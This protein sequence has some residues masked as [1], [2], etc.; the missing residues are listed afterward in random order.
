MRL[1]LL[2]LF[3]AAAAIAQ[4]P[5]IQISQTL[6]V[7]GGIRPA[8]MN[9]TITLS[10][11]YT[12]QDG[13]F[14]VVQSEA[15]IPIVGGHLSTCQPAG[16][17]I[18]AHYSVTPTPPLTKTEEYDRYWK[19]PPSGGPYPL[20]QIEG[21]TPITPP[22]TV[23][24]SWLANG[25]DGVV[26]ISGGHGDARRLVPNDLP[27]LVGPETAAALS[28][29]W[30][31]R[32]TPGSAG[33]G[34]IAYSPELR[35]LVVVSDADGAYGHVM[36]SD[37][38]GQTWTSH[39]T[40]G[41]AYEWNALMWVDNLS[42]FIVLPHSATY[43]GYMTSS[44]GIAWT[45]HANSTLTGGYF[46][47]VAW[48][49][50]LGI[51]CAV[52]AAA[53]GAG[54]PMAARSSD[55]SSWIAADGSSPGGSD[56]VWV[57]E[58]SLF[59][60]VRNNLNY[61]STS[62]DCNHWTA[63]S[64]I[65][66]TSSISTWGRVE[67]APQIGKLVVTSTKGTGSDLR[68]ASSPDAVHWTA[69]PSTDDSA[70]WLA[71]SWSP[72]LGLFSAISNSTAETMY[73]FDGDH[74]FAGVAPAPSTGWRR[75]L[76]VPEY[77]EF[78]AS[79]ATG[80]TQQIM[81]S[82]PIG[83]TAFSPQQVSASGGTSQPSD[84]IV[85]GTGSGLTS[86]D[87]ATCDTAG[88]CE[89]AGSL[90]FGGYLGGLLHTD[91]NGHLSAAPV[92]LDS[93]D[94]A[95]VLQPAYG[96]TGFSMCPASAICIAMPNDPVAGTTVN[97]MVDVNAGPLV[98][99][100]PIWV[101]SHGLPIG[102]CIAQCG[103]TGSAIIQIS[104]V[105]QVVTDTSTASGA[106]LVPSITNPGQ[107]SNAGYAT[108]NR[109][110][111]A[112]PI[113]ARSLDDGVSPGLHPVLLMLGPIPVDGFRQPGPLS[114]IPST[115]AQ[116]SVYFATDAPAGSNLRLCIAL[117]T[118]AAVSLPWAQLTGVPTSFA[119]SGHAVT[120]QYGGSDPVG[121]STPS[122]NA[123]PQAD[124]TGKL[125]TGWIPTLNQ[126]TTGTAAN[127]T[128]VVAR[129]NGGLAGGTPGTGLLRDG[130]TP[131]ASELSGD[132]TTSGNNAV[133]VVRVNGVSYPASPATNKVPVVT[134]AN[135]ITYEAVPNAALA[136]SSIT[137]ST[138]GPLGGGG[139][140]SLGGSLTLTCATCTQTVA[141]GTAALGTL[142]ISSGAC[143]SVV[144]V[145]ASGVAVTDDILADFNGDPTATTGYL[146]STS[147]TLTIFKYPSLN[148]VNFKVC[149]LTGGSITPGAVTL[150]WRV[151]R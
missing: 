33:W 129:A 73:S 76:W 17:S 124:G 19:I 126:D 3:T 131:T 93:Q 39:S 147:G 40:P 42:E 139:T 101:S 34:N 94:V 137:V 107:L 31:I 150:N 71:T 32:N 13:A 26:V 4:P 128:G 56:V 88:N 30:T 86:S 12:A 18:Q 64:P 138:S 11:G 14:T 47:S 41:D 144:T 77:G 118:W 54:N 61:V 90:V 75:E 108:V 83:P 80:P 78:I 113:A 146:P 55:L 69:H 106:L 35:R 95:G 102:V 21:S 148:G 67:W 49:P 68:T 127:V 38:G 91:E 37:D 143:A 116:G 36:T 44:D 132:A 89:F 141:S 119:P 151:V 50:Q 6:Y 22:T 57:P 136:N 120:H 84:Q 70:W 48:S 82:S 96:G 121:T 99:T 60:S 85:I 59:V 66:T 134:G 52:Q 105:A 16:S 109:I 123:I 5:C 2:A 29:A 24:P 97:E 114:S 87:N 58:L 45:L 149:N 51:A 110:P 43:A 133:T 115:C 100:Y 111:T 103:T 145:S 20:S 140:L 23:A 15:P 9:G 72:Q 65:G 74:W 8:L 130:A 7:A 28:S 10:I 92:N 135:T 142:A 27:P 98:K 122:A 1:T 53:S 81:T 62:P 104:G 79:N 117:N 46:D 125:A 63:Q 112:T 25:N